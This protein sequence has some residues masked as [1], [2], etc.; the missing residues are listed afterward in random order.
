VHR[1]PHDV[2]GMVRIDSRH[3][4]VDTNRS[5]KALAAEHMQAAFSADDL[6]RGADRPRAPF[7]GIGL[8][9]GL[10]GDTESHRHD[11][12][13]RLECFRPGRSRLMPYWPRT[14]Y[15]AMTMAAEC[16]HFAGQTCH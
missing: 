6:G 4:S 11:A 1:Y 15:P 12:L 5:R 14:L 13:R 3:E 10:S 7:L 16:R 9:K 8:A 2:V